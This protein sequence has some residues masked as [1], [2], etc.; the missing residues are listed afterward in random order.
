MGSNS[1][2]INVDL[3][4]PATYLTRLDYSSRFYFNLLVL[5]RG[6][7]LSGSVSVILSIL[8]GGELHTFLTRSLLGP[9]DY[10]FVFVEL[11]EIPPRIE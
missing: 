11:K 6:V 1:G 2:L 9:P 4:Q 3:A 10:T 7:S 8:C 5:G